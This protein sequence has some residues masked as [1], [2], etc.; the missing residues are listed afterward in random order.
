[1]GNVSRLPGGGHIEWNI[2]GFREIRTSDAAM[3]GVE[4]LAQAVAN[5]CGD[6]YEAQTASIT[7][8]RGRARAAVITT[9]KAINYEAKHHTLAG[10][11]SGKRKR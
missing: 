4:G 3:A 2:D 8:G 1:M 9:G 11:A 6:G 7:G 10:F 5:Q